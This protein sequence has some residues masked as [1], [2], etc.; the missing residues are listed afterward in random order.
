MKYG[1]LKFRAF[2]DGK[3]IYQNQIE[4][5]VIDEYKRL[6]SFFDTIRE[7][8]IVMQFTGL[9]DSKGFDIYEGDI[10]KYDNS[11]YGYGDPNQPPD[12]FFCLESI[13]E[14]YDDNDYTYF[15]CTSGEVV[16]TKY[17]NPNLL[18]KL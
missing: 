12:F 16:G 7:D 2:D 17:E 5:V 10:I 4:H 18:K 1:E 3:M 14:L 15:K 8:A 6:Q 13:T 9:R 11:N